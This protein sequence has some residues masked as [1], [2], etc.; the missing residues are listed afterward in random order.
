MGSE[1]ESTE[2]LNAYQRYARAAN[3]LRIH[4]AHDT[5]RA[6]EYDW[7]RERCFLGDATCD[8]LVEAE[9]R[10]IEISAVEA[11]ERKLI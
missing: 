3:A 9:K 10:R 6:V 5:V 4:F 7:A 11:R 1:I 2:T 8:C